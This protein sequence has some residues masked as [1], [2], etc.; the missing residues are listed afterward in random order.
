M[1][2]AACGC[3]VG[4]CSGHLTASGSRSDFSGVDHE[5]RQSF[6][7]LIA[8]MGYSRSHLTYWYIRGGIQLDFEHGT[9]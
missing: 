8:Y 4:G 9:M 3:R 1:T 7:V 6:S 2:R 5:G